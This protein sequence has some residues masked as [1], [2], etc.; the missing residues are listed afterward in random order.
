MQIY[1]KQSVKACFIKAVFINLYGEKL[2]M[3]KNQAACSDFAN[4]TL[5]SYENL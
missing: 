3:S 5:N 1:T 4:V 2:F